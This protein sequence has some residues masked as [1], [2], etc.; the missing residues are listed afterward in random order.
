MLILDW[1][2]Y[3]CVGQIKSSVV[4]NSSATHYGVLFFRDAMFRFEWYMFS[5]VKIDVFG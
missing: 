1:S 2:I 5:D 3:F 4:T